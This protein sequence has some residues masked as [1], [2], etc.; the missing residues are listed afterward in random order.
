[1]EESNQSILENAIESYHEAIENK[2]SGFL[3]IA[4][5]TS[6][7]KWL[8]Y[9]KEFNNIETWRIARTICWSIFMNPDT[10]NLNVDSLQEANAA[11]IH[12]AN[13]YNE[14]GEIEKGFTFRS[15]IKKL[16][17][18]E[19]NPQET[20]DLI[21]CLLLQSVIVENNEDESVQ[22]KYME[23]I[24]SICNDQLEGQPIYNESLEMANKIYQEY[25]SQSKH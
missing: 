10:Y 2:S 5:F 6:V 20:G 9:E 16:N 11:G 24:E 25:R 14:T 12:L 7:C 8:R 13:A 23:D 21:L 4:S 3:I 1:M 18:F 22:K 17:V 19:L 15:F